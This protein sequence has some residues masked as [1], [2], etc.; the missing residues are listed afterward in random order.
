MRHKITVLRQPDLASGAMPADH[1][2]AI[3]V[4]PK[5]YVRGRTLARNGK[6]DAGLSPSSRQD[7]LQI[8]GSLDGV[9][10]GPWAVFAL[11]LAGLLWSYWPTLGDL[12]AF[13]RQN[14]DYS[15]GALV[16]LVA[17][18]VIGSRRKL[19]REAPIETCWAGLVLLLAAQAVRFFGVL[20]M[21]GSL[22]R[23]S[24]LLSVGA[25]C[26]LLLGGRI[27]RQLASV[28]AFLALMFPL[29][30]RAHEALALPLQNFASRSAVVGLEMLGYL[31][32]QEG[33]VLSLSDQTPVA[34][35]EA[36][37]GLRM[38]TAFVI[39]A[40]A[41]TFVVHRPA[42][43]KLVIVASSIPVAILA[44]T[45][46]LVATVLVLEI[47]GS[48]A[49]EQFFHNSAGIVMIPFAWA[50]LMG[51]LWLLRWMG[52]GPRRSRER[53]AVPAAAGRDGPGSRAA[54]R[55]A[56]GLPRA[57]SWLVLH[58]PAVT[59]VVAIMV[60]AGVGHR[61]L[62]AR[63][64]RA[65]G[66]SLAL[67]QALSTLPLQLERWQGRDVPLDE[68]VRRIAGDDDFL[69]RQY[70]D[71]TSGRTIGL[72]V[73]YVGRPRSRLGHRPDVC[74]PAHGF[75]ETSR[76]PMSVK[77]R[78]GAE[79]PAV[80]Y[81]FANPQPGG[82]RERVLATYVING[83]YVTDVTASGGLN[84]RS[85]GLGAKRETYVARVQVSIQ[86]S[87]D[88]AADVALLCEFASL[89]RGPLAA[90]MPAPGGQ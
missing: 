28:L 31:V 50:V 77:S 54:S 51:E 57:R 20:Y 75:E 7:R 36:C 5:G 71:G 13:W 61:V 76:Q 30:V 67:R 87:G 33:N 58:R 25:G 9:V 45:L 2:A 34:V 56:R 89:L 6:H 46:R 70:L 37:S 8:R 19:L 32:K 69:N 39:V 17:A 62:A 23:L 35:A 73:G 14:S 79:V 41:L 63:I 84:G 81:E 11:L 29:P 16:P 4:P 90:M 44:N 64:D 27:T 24:F 59:A 83:Q 40:A 47:V 10:A 26:L 15:A 66:Q 18:Y 65:L 22:E 60:L 43:Q 82:P 88:R 86:A 78:D 1:Q 49:G 72:Y 21:F 53:Q 85:V 74:Y 38:L 12:V 3:V 80:L 48:K 68:Q 52:G 55:D 42:W